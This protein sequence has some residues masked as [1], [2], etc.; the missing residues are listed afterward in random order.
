MVEQKW[1]SKM[2]GTATNACNAYYYYVLGIA[3]SFLPVFSYV[4]LS[5]RLVVRYYS[6]HFTD[7][8][9]EE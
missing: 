5:T 6:L 7:E 1:N 9:T 8:G 3:I 4:T 2:T